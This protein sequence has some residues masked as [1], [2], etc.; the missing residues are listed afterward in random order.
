MFYRVEVNSTHKATRSGIPFFPRFFASK[1]PPKY[2]I[3][4]AGQTFCLIT[5]L[6]LIYV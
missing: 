5:V 2:S 6:Q 3:H 1:F 4:T